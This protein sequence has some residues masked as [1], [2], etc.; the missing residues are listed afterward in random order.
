MANFSMNARF[1]VTKTIAAAALGLAL[2]GCTANNAAP[3]AS[4]ST[5]SIGADLDLAA[6]ACVSVADISE[7]ERCK[8]KFDQGIEATAREYRAQSAGRQ[9]IRAPTPQ[10]V[11]TPQRAAEHETDWDAAA[12]LLLLGGTAFLNGYN[13]G[14]PATT[15]CFTT[16]MMTQ[17]TSL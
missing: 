6:L 3:R 2:S 7:R 14:R 5:E 8:I 11:P 10:P 4:L 12:S 1:A 16:G 15:T 9:P 17:C 13:Q